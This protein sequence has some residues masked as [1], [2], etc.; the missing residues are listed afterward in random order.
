MIQ[1][2]SLS[3]K[4]S[5]FHCADN[6]FIQKSLEKLNASKKLSPLE[7]TNAAIDMAYNSGPLSGNF[8][9]EVDM[10]LPGRQHGLVFLSKENSFGNKNILD[11]YPDLNSD[12]FKNNKS[13]QHLDKNYKHNYS[14]IFQ[15]TYDQTRECRRQILIT[16]FEKDKKS[17]KFNFTGRINVEICDPSLIQLFSAGAQIFESKGKK[18]ETLAQFFEALDTLLKLGKI[19]EENVKLIKQSLNT[20]NFPGVYYAKKPNGHIAPRFSVEIKNLYFNNL[21]ETKECEMNMIPSSPYLG[22]LEHET[23]IFSDAIQHDAY[24]DFTTNQGTPTNMED[25]MFMHFWLSY[26]DDNGVSTRRPSV[27][28]QLLNKTKK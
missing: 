13:T 18:M 24:I 17:K 15:I 3:S 23:H 9:N 26:W 14:G 21:A 4:A 1:F 11:M 16:G 19:P 5:D 22:I 6:S 12:I 20:D 7:E 2:L 8:G 27:L 10:N 28:N 25:T